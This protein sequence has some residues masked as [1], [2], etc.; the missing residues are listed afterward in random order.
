MGVKNRRESSQV[1]HS[2][3]P[4]VKQSWENEYLCGNLRSL[5]LEA[6]QL[7]EKENGKEKEKKEDSFKINDCIII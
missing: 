4:T 7:K 1:F 2:D 3:S 5:N 6:K